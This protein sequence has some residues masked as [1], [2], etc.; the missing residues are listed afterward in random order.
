MDSVIRDLQATRIMDY[1]LICDHRHVFLYAKLL[2]D[3]V[4]GLSGGLMLLDSN[5]LID[6]IYLDF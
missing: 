5:A 4:T 2:F 1:N 3:T 6:L